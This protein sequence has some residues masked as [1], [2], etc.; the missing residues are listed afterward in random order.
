MANPPG[1]ALSE[2]QQLRKLE[3]T[4]AWKRRNPERVSGYSRMRVPQVRTREQAREAQ[5]RQLRDP[6]KRIRNSLA[7]RLSHALAGA[8]GNR[9][10]FVERF[11]CSLQQLRE[12]L[13]GQFG[14][15]M[16]WKNYG[17]WHVDHKRAC[18]HFDLLDPIQRRECFHFTNLQPLWGPD[19]LAKGVSL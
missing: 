9:A 2:A 3:T 1:Y 19:N 17:E 13:E 16:T 8:S 15:G 7:S 10:S 14:P 18:K 6:V 5:R 11:G 4:R 12:H